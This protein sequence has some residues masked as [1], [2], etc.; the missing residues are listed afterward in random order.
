MNFTHS[1]EK[2]NQILF[3]KSGNNIIDNSVLKLLKT[4]H[5]SFIDSFYELK[6]LKHNIFMK[7]I[8][9]N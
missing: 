3:I 5:K 8:Y 2:Q 6:K 7:N 4:Y 9:E 1:L